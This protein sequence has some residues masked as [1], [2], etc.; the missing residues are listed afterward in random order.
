YPAFG[1]CSGWPVS[2]A[3]VRRFAGIAAAAPGCGVAAVPIFAL[4][5]P[6]PGGYFAVA[7]WVV[8]TCFFLYVTNQLWLGGGTGVSLAG[9]LSGLPPVV[10]EAY[11][12]W[13]ALALMAVI[14]AGGF[15]PLRGPV[16]A[17]RAA[18]GAAPPGAGA[19][20]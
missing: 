18:P 6:L 17:G 5:R 8:A 11:T 7:T 12:Y 10:R 1:V 9:R 20:G 4:L 19:R 2:K 15:R 13:L 16:G 3:G 14:V